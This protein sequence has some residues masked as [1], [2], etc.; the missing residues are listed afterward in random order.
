MD[1]AAAGFRPG[2]A[3]AIYLPMTIESVAIYLGIIRAGCVAVS[4]ADSLAAEEIA[5]RLRLS[6]R[7]GSLHAGRDPARRQAIAALCQGDRSRRAARD[8]DFR[9]G[10]RSNCA[11]ATSTWS[12]FLGDSERFDRLPG[13]SARAD[14]YLVLLGHDRRTEGDSLDAHHA[15]QVRAST[16]TCIRTFSPTIASPGRRTWAG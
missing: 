12:D 6:E 8:R 15:D 5:V 2:D 16:A 9:R 10:R 1:C 11:P 7:K 14:E 4:I 3:L 13:R